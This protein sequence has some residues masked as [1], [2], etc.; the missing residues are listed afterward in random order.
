MYTYVTVSSTFTKR[1]KS[2]H[3]GAAAAL[4]DGLPVGDGVLVVAAVGSWR[5]YRYSAGYA[6]NSAILD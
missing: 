5:G 2:S 3:L 4:L 1:G 6:V